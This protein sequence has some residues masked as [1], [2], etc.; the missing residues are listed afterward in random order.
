[1]AS[2]TLDGNKIVVIC[3][4]AR[5]L[6]TVTVD[7]SDSP[8]TL[9]QGIMAALMEAADIKPQYSGEI[10]TINVA[11]AADTIRGQLLAVPKQEKKIEVSKP[12]ALGKTPAAPARVPAPPKPESVPPRR[13][14]T[15]MT[16]L[17]ARLD[18]CRGGDLKRVA[19][20][21]GSR[22]QLDRQTASPAQQA[23][24][25]VAVFTALSEIPSF[26]MGSASKLK[27]YHELSL[28]SDYMKTYKGIE[29]A[30]DDVI[31]AA[32]IYIRYFLLELGTQEKPAYAPELSQLPACKKA[33]DKLQQPLLGLQPLIGPMDT[34]TIIA[35]ALYIRRWN[36]TDRQKV[37]DNEVQP[38]QTPETLAAGQRVMAQLPRITGR[39]DTT[40]REIKVNV[41]W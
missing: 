4:G 36:L 34:Q 20:L 37:P 12:A 35:A 10:S 29:G 3:S 2:V 33:M 21:Y 6:T 31:N 9:K 32:N 18:E 8:K 25:T 15:D 22:D 17:K 41:K 16:W 39:I 24:A 5:I 1:M 26:R 38:W 14:E 7:K 28:L 13:S 23:A 40:N 19:A 11:T 30:G 27:D